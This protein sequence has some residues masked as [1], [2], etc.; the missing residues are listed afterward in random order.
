[1]WVLGIDSGP[2]EEQKPSLQSPF[3]FLFFYVLSCSLLLVEMARL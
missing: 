1:M 3:I 2:L